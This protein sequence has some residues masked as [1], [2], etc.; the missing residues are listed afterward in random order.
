[1]GGSR[2]LTADLSKGIQKYEIYFGKCKGKKYG[3]FG[4]EF[5]PSI[6]EDKMTINEYHN[7][8]D[9]LEILANNFIPPT[10]TL[11]QKL[12]ISSIILTCGVAFLFYLFFDNNKEKNEKLLEEEKEKDEISKYIDKENEKWEEYGLKFTFRQSF[13]RS[14]KGRRFFNGEVFVLTIEKIEEIDDH[15][16]E[17]NV[18]V[19]NDTSSVYRHTPSNFY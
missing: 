5:F 8:I 10:L 11:T 12:Q 3:T 4:K 18:C 2:S 1:M 15:N 6:C 9:N 13:I 16:D 7:L 19:V 14:C 17:Y